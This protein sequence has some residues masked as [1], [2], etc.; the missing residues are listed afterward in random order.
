MGSGV[1]ASGNERYMKLR[2]RPQESDQNAAASYL[3]PFRLR[4][5]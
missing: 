5:R 1:W 2:G 4:L 3:L